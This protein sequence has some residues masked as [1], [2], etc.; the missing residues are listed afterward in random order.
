[1]SYHFGIIC[2]AKFFRVVSSRNDVIML[3]SI[4]SLGIFEFREFENDLR[5]IPCGNIAYQD[6]SIRD[7]MAF[8]L[9]LTKIST[10]LDKHAS[11]YKF[12]KRIA[13]LSEA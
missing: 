10:A 9:S 5:S 12:S 3:N 1:M 8:N 13:P 11:N 4:V 6:I 7:Y 2:K